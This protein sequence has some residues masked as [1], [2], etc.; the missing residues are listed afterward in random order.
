MASKN[1][2]NNLFIMN[3]RLYCY[4]VMSFDMKNIGAT[5]RHLINKT[6]KNQISHN[7]E[8]YVNDMLVKSYKQSIIWQSLRKLSAF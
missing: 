6:F 7:M 8:I 2:E 5:Y 4:K 3:Q 1:E